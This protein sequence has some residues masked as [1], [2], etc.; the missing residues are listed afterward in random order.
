VTRA[1]TILVYHPEPGE[2]RAYA[3]LIP[4][5]GGFRVAA[6]ATPA[7]AAAEI[8]QTEV[9]Y[10]W[11]FPAALLSRAARLRWFQNMGAGVERVLVPELSPEVR[12]LVITTFTP[13]R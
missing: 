7:E 10:A 3:R 11:N 9:L 1:R 6:C 13:A 12:V 8:A 4:R 5:T 2:A